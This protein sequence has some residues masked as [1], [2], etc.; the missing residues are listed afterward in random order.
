MISGCAAYVAFSDAFETN[1]GYVSNIARRYSYS[2]DQ[3]QDFA[4]ETWLAVYKVWETKW[5]VLQE[6]NLRG[7]LYRIVVNVARGH[8]STKRRESKTR[9]ISLEDLKPY[10]SHLRFEDDL[11]SVISAVDA[12]NNPLLQAFFQLKPEEQL[13]IRLNTVGTCAEAARFLQIDERAYRT[14][15]SRVRAK[16]RRLSATSPS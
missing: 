10:E 1:R 16:L 11:D 5:L 8:F 7:W 9:T 4:S 12:E 6:T 15:L 2:D 13:T 3:A 14:R